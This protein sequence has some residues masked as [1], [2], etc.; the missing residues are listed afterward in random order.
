MGFTSTAA[1]A[2]ALALGVWAYRLATLPAGYARPRT[3]VYSH[4]LNAALWLPRLLKLHPAFES[5]M[6]M[7]SLQREASKRAKLTDWGDDFEGDAFSFRDGYAFAV[8]LLN[9]A[10]LTPFGQFGAFDYLMRRLYA[11]LRVI[12]AVKEAG[13]RAALR[14]KSPV[15]APVFV[16]GLPRCGTTLL[17]RL[18][19]LDPNVQFPKTYELLDPMPRYAA[20]EDRAKDAKKRSEYW[21]SKLDLIKKVVPQIEGACRCS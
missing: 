10:T 13:G 15:A 2:G 8:D 19:S 9:S 21:E 12:N 6:T 3:T 5:P 16:L 17:H 4:L 18:L 11:R 20:P 1:L 7:A 14:K